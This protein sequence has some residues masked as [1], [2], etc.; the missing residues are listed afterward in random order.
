[1]STLPD[2]EYPWPTCPC[3][4]NTLAR[5]T[6]DGV[7]YCRDCGLEWET[8]HG[9][10]DREPGRYVDWSAKPCGHEHVADYP[11]YRAIPCPLPAGHTSYHY[12][13]NEKIQ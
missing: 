5:W 10:G 13:R 11:G 9:P 3:C 6:D 12:E 4:D 7:W 8:P 2:L 1:M